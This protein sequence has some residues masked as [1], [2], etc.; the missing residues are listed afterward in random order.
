[1]SRFTILLSGGIYLGKMLGIIFTVAK[2]FLSLD[3]LSEGGRDGS[4]R[5]VE[6]KD[7]SAPEDDACTP[8]DIPLSD[9]TLSFIKSI[10][11]SSTSF[12]VALISSDIQAW[13]S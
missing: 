10:K 6:G 4:T 8:V 3:H 1:M 7:G 13:V 11:T 12:S 9:M 2:S 5:S